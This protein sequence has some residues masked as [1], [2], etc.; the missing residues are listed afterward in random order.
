M[1]KI[2]IF[3]NQAGH[4]MKILQ[5]ANKVPYPPRDGGSIATFSLS[6]GFRELGHEVTVLAMST[7]KHPVKAT[8]IPRQLSDDIRFILVE[9]D[10][11]LK[12]ANALRNVLF[13][14]MPYN[15]ERFVSKELGDQ[16][17]QLLIDEEFDVIQLEGL[18]LSPY[19]PLIKELSDG[20]I[21]M[22]AHNIEHEIWE[23]TVKQRSGLAKLYTGIIARRVKKM[24]TENLNS[25]DAMV[26]ITGRDEKMLKSLGCRLPSHVSP[27]GIDMNDYRPYKDKPEYPSVFHIGALDWSPNQEGLRWFISHCWKTLQKKYPGLKFYI[28]GRNAPDSFR[29]INEPNVV[30]MGEVDDAYAFMRG[31]AIMVV[32]LLSGSGMRIKIIEGMALGKSIV[33]T[34]IGTEGIAVTDGKE[35]LI[36]DGHEK[37]TAAIES[38]LDNFDKFEAIG[39]NAASFVEKHYDN[40]S[41]SKA[42]AAFYKEQI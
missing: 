38:L 14:K 22:R 8:D 17:A 20:L 24:E 26:P 42:L 5:I 40:L 31:K 10:T 1:R 29:K 27:T 23:R 34:S 11:R 9:V 33:S 36:A 6:R 35:I 13:S 18:Y 32:P 21:V 4:A 7:S 37:F 16:L 3:A 39:S 19:V 30:F 25:Y 12:P 28:A 2:D 15:A 41:I